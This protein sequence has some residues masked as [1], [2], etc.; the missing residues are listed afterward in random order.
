[1]LRDIRDQIMRMIQEDVS[2]DDSLSSTFTTA[3]FEACGNPGLPLNRSYF[4]LTN[5]VVDR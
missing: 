5:K 3:Y 2:L 1:M 4:S